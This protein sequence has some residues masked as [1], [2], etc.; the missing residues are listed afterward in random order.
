MKLALEDTTISGSI[1]E[2]SVLGVGERLDTLTQPKIE[3]AD[4]E[5]DKTRSIMG[6][7]SFYIIS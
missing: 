5:I 7:F 2:D 4:V 6:K 1:L 3:G